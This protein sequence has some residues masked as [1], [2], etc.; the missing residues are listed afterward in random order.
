MTSNMITNPND[1]IAPLIDAWCGRR[2]LKAL[3]CL[4]PAWISNNGMTDGWQTLRAELK[5][6]YAMCSNLPSDERDE[7]KRA[8]AAIDLGLESR[9]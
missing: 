9:A 7:L 2:E 6:T 3:S 5:H 8:I 1:V 4:L